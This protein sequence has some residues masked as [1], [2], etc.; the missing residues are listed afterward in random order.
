MQ[1]IYEKFI[2]LHFC[3]PLISGQYL[4]QG[5]IFSK[6]PYS[7]QEVINTASNFDNLSFL[8]I[9]IYFAISILSG[10]FSWSKLEG[11]WKIR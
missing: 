7:V 9:I 1:K 5:K 6:L 8:I 11:R 10:V 3:F 2:R 4:D